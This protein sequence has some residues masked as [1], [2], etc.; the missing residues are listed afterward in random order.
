MLANSTAADRRA[1]Q[2]LDGVHLL[3]DDLV[4]RRRGRAVRRVRALGVGQLLLQ[5]LDL[6]E[7]PL[8]LVLGAGELARR[9]T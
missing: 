3:A 4:E 7:H 6:L 2:L 8:E 1:D 5:P 9:A